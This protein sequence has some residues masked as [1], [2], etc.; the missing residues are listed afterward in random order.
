MEALAR[1]DCERAVEYLVAALVAAKI[2]SAPG[3]RHAVLGSP[4]DAG[5]KSFPSRMV[6]SVQAVSMSLGLSARTALRWAERRGRGC[7]SPVC[8]TG[9]A[10]RWWNSD[11]YRARAST[12]PRGHPL[13]AAS[14]AFSAAIGRGD[15][16][17][18]QYLRRPPRL[19]QDHPDGEHPQPRCR[20]LRRRAAPPSRRRPGQLCRHDARDQVAHPNSERGLLEPKMADV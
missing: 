17:R 16:P 7:G 15:D 2:R 1:E 12:G 13:W 6:A 20:R 10:P 18:A 4:G 11:V 8:A 14:A 3:S 5:L 9:S 19:S